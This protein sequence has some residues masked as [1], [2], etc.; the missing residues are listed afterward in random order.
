[1]ARQESSFFRPLL[2]L[3]EQKQLNGGECEIKAKINVRNIFELMVSIPIT[4]KIYFLSKKVSSLRRALE[5]FIW[6]RSS[7]SFLEY[8]KATQN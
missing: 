7:F 5:D 8:K 2:M 4:L 6:R 1:M 3:S